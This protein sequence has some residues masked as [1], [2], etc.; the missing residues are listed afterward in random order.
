[1]AVDRP[2]YGYSGFGNKEP[3]IEKQ[4]RMIKPILDTL[5]ALQR[6]VLIS[7]GSYGTSIACRLV[8]DNPGMIDGMVL[9][10]PS[11]APGEERLFWFT[12]A[13]ESPLVN[14]F[15]PRM[16]QVAN[17]EKVHHQE[18]LE[19][20]LPFWSNIKIPIIY[21][22]GEKDELIDTSNASFARRHLVHAPYL[23]INMIK[24]R[25]HFL[26]FDEHLLISRKI[27]ELYRRVKD[28]PRL[29]HFN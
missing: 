14:W 22:Q 19:K 17:A 28:A 24:G 8:M 20:M 5:H 25:K 23:E 10:A 21:I 2:G 6:P 26:A 13:V 7:S 3:S 11:L 9:V 27:M 1:L 29:K 15:I 4:A 16:L 12:H 18:E